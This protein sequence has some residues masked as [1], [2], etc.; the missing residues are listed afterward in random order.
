MLPASCGAVQRD[1]HTAAASTAAGETLAPCDVQV[2]E[3][4]AAGKDPY[5][6]SF[7]R[8]HTA[9]QLQEE[10]AGLEDGEVRL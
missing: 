7:Q 8:T 4:R 10:F 2:A 3:L 1:L 6:Y 5:A 9:Q